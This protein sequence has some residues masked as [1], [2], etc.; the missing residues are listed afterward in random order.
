M[1]HIMNPISSTVALFIDAD[2]APAKK[3]DFIITE[4]A[5][6]GSVMVRKAYG[7][8]KED[9]LK[10]WESVLLDYAI[11]PV[12]QFDY[13]KG[14]NATD[15]AMTID[16]MDLL[17]QGKI[18]VFCIVSSDSDFTPLVMRVKMEGKQVIG[19]GEQKAPKSLVAACNKFL[20]L[21]NDESTNEEKSF[22][23]QS[24]HKKPSNELKMDTALMNLLRKAVSESCDESGW[25]ALNRVG[26]LINNQSSF[27]S[28]NFGY[29]KLGDL[30]RAIDIFETKLSDS[31]NQ[32]YV[33]NK[34]A[35]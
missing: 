11:A 28:K 3:I 18:D 29:A 34:R 12:Q 19:F 14:K 5:T 31:R 13:T 9:R 27:D 7:N 1:S 8:W 15:M 21:N 33:R 22:S 35:K 20:Y 25:A 30:F 2:N 32:L 23:Q 10:S 26:Q 17:S 16:V 4:L 6:Y 24:S